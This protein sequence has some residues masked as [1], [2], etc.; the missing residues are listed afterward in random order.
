M[1][2]AVIPFAMVDRGIVQ[3]E[4]RNHLFHPAFF[5]ASQALAGIPVC[6]VL[7]ALVSV[8]VLLMTGIKGNVGFF[9]IL[10]LTFLCADATSMFVAHIAPEMISALCISSG[11]FGVFTMV[12]GFLVT[13]SQFPTGLGW[14]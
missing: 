2:V 10:F 3:K 7:S 9:F 13:P 6:L 4:V 14:L 11:I 1:S 5:H 8:I 12:M